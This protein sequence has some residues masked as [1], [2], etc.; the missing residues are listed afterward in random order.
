MPFRRDVLWRKVLQT[1]LTS[2]PSRHAQ[3]EDLML[4]ENTSVA[5]AAVSRR[6]RSAAV[7]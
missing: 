7:T 4:D 5:A 3:R 1:L 2:Q 6:S